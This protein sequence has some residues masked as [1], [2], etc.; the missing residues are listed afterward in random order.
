MEKTR[1]HR[2][3]V[4][5][6]GIIAALFVV[7]FLYMGIFQGV[8]VETARQNSACYTVTGVSETEIADPTAPIGVRR[9]FR[10]TLDE[11]GSGDQTLAFYMVHHEAEVWLDGEL[12]YRQTLAEGNRVGRTPGSNWVLIPLRAEDAGREVR[13]VLTPV[14]RIVLHRAVEFRVGSLYE[15]YRA[16]LRQDLPQLILAVVCIALGVLMMVVSPLLYRLRRTGDR[17]QFF[18]GSLTLLLGIWKGA[19]TR[20]TPFLF[21]SN[22]QV[23]SYLSLGALFL[24]PIPAA[25]YLRGRFEKSGEKPLQAAALAA[26]CAAAA[27]LLIQV[28]GAADLRQILPLAHAMIILTALTVLTVA[29]VQKRRGKMAHRTRSWRLSLLLACGVVADL[30]IYYWSGNSSGLGFTLLAF[31]VYALTLFVMNIADTN[32]RANTDLYTGLISKNR[33]EELVEHRNPAEEP[34]GMIMLDLNGLKQVNDN[35]GHEM[36]DKMIGAFANVLRNIIPPTNTICRWGGDE[37]TVLITNA[38]RAKVEEYLN[39]IAE[40]VEAYNRSGEKPEIH[41]AAGY[42]LGEEFPGLSHR[43]LLTRAD[44]RMYGNKQAWYR[45]HASDHM[46]RV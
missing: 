25:L 35:L 42:A 12:V 36:G 16:Q 38:T 30:A 15:F 39:R 5:T 1:L 21:E 9:E 32:R 27:A 17:D 28:L 2:T 46:T 8:S 14:Y 7:F 26:S 34:V 44:E 23:L 37:F 43:E 45:E 18:L 29:L 41:Y 6:Y 10:F 24:A 19:D 40:A 11:I 3:A 20:F 13:V 33:W 31:L 22:P 4:F